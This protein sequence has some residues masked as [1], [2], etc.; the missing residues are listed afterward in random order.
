L[1]L[2]IALTF[3]LNARTLRREEAADAGEAGTR[4]ICEGK[5]HQAHELAPHSPIGLS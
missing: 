4:T 3:L 5:R 2:A 1:T